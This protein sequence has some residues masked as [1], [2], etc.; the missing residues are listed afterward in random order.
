MVSIST[1]YHS[2]NPRKDSYISFYLGLTDE[3]TSL[4]K[5]RLTNDHNPK[6]LIIILWKIKTMK[7]KLYKFLY[8]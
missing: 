4:F 3:T 1:N 6:I 2:L 8:L 5:H 7:S